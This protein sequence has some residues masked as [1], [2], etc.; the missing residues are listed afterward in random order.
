MTV[1]EAARLAGVSAR[2]VRLYESLG[3]LDGVRRTASGYR[4]FG[5]EDVRL[6]RFVGR[7][8]ALGL[9]LD[10]IR[11]LV[12]TRRRGEP[13]S[14]V[15]SRLLERHV[16]DTDR[17]IT[18]LTSRRARLRDLLGRA[19]AAAEAGGPVHLCRLTEPAEPRG[20]AST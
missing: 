15:V 8:R 16:R 2:A 14:A 17:Q 6:L 13:P 10:E 1:G 4:L 20:D 7:A 9:R 5:P 18:E 3:I 11:S 19:G 12:E